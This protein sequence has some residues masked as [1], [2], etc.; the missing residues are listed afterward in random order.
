MAWTATSSWARS[1]KDGTEET[2]RKLLGYERTGNMK[3]LD[4][5]T[6]RIRCT[7]VGYVTE[8]K[9]E[10]DELVGEGHCHIIFTDCQNIKDVKQVKGTQQF[11]QVQ[12]AKKACDDNNGVY[13]LH[14]ISLP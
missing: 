8:D 7:T 1:W 6:F 2:T 9:E 13:D 3:A 10:Y 5:T 11:F 4:N 12:G 14:T